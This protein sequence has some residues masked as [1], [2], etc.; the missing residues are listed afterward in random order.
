MNIVAI[1]ERQFEHQAVHGVSKHSAGVLLC[2]TNRKEEGGGR[3]VRFGNE[4]SKH[5][6][7]PLAD[8]LFL[9]FRRFGSG[10]KHGEIDGDVRGATSS[11]R[12][13]VIGRGIGE[14]FVPEWAEYAR[15]EGG[16]ALPG[17]TSL[18]DYL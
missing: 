17:T 6:C 9:V 4:E 13:D 8:K 15:G 16:G 11:I 2:G 7:P 5:V 3:D 1:A 18:S 12:G 14:P 10:V